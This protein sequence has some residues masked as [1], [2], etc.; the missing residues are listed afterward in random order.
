MNQTNPSQ[1]MRDQS[2][3]LQSQLREM[4]AQGRATASE[5][6]DRE[7]L[8]QLAALYQKLSEALRQQNTD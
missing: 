2:R 6:E 3:E 7:K 8:K 5:P 4:I 1:K